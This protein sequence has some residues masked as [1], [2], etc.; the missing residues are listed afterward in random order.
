M[1]MLSYKEN[2]I[3]EDALVA[4]KF[5]FMVH[6]HKGDWYHK[7]YE[8]L[9]GELNREVRELEEAVTVESVISECADIINYAAMI[10]DTVK[11]NKL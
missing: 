8:Q 3:L 7:G 11:R 5:K 9:V 1:V 6:R 4:A 2:E 10:I